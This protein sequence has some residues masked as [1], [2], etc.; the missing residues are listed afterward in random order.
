MQRSFGPYDIVA[1]MG[2]GGMAD[3]YL[4]T[5]EGAADFHRPVVIKVVQ[6]HLAKDDELVKMFLDEARVAAS[7]HHPNVIR[8]VDLGELEGR[9]YLVME[10]VHGASL[11][12]L[13]KKLV[14]L[15]RR[16][17][18]AAAIA[19]VADAAAG[20][21][22]AHEAKS[23]DGTR[24]EVVHRDVSPHNVIVGGDGVVRVIDFG[25]AKAR[26]RLHATQ[27]IKV[28]GKLRYM[29]PEQLAGGEVDRRSDVFA[30]GVVL[31]EALSGHRL[32]GKLE[33]ADVIKRLQRGVMPPLPRGVDVP[34]EV[35]SLIA[36]CF[37]ADPEARP[38]SALRLR[39]QLL[40]AV[41]AAHEFDEV[42]RAALLLAVLG[43]ELDDRSK[44]LAVAGANTLD[45]S[46]LSSLPARALQ[47]WT[48]PLPPQ[49]SFDPPPAEDPAPVA[50]RPADA[51]PPRRS[52][53]LLSIVVGGL[54]AIA[55]AAVYFYLDSREPSAAT[56]HVESGPD[57][58]P[59]DE[60]EP[61]GE[62]AI[63]DG[64]DGEVEPPEPQ[65][66]TTE[67]QPTPPGMRRTPMVSTMRETTM[68]AGAEATM[69]PSMQPQRT[70]S[71]FP[72]FGTNEL[73]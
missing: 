34:H 62:S 36:Q 15:G 24:L 6:K 55:G 30:L 49:V 35:R 51:V 56:E 69:A 3:L 63:G 32:F 16:L 70:P 48:E 46:E 27:G 44:R 40:D 17:A 59:P 42:Q 68:A 18:P 71:G 65:V 60:L 20:L 9:Y 12:D 73:P 50:T 57:P 38:R 29:P 33:D 19:L 22:A 13:L 39:T 41:P 28:K 45:T 58:E 23:D 7:I 26:D 14:S 72:T 31:W 66:E 37:R 47:D 25:L 64:E 5:M 11:S 52:L 61:Q 53:L 54:A 43:A 21:H 1:R 2:S 10:Y 67:T 4:A 8:I